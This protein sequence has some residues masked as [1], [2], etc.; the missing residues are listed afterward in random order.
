MGVGMNL[1]EILRDKKMTI[2]QLAED[3]GISVNT[4]YSITKRDS[5]RVDTIIV[6]RIA[7]ALQVDPYSLYSFDQATEALEE[8]INAKDARARL[9]A[10][11]DQLN[12]EG[13][14][15][16]ADYAEDIL[17]SYKKGGDEG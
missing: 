1:K 14:V 11:L 3:S 4:L 6:Q 16:V 2:K 17:P 9:D 13:Q 10:A 15:K 8:R 12:P 7:A 5:E